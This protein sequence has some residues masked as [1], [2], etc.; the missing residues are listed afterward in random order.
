MNI[1][2]K[3]SWHVRNKDNVERVRRDEENARKDEKER[4]K[5]AALAEQ[6]ART[7]LLR[8]RAAKKLIEDDKTQETALVLADDK[9]KHINFFAEIEEGLR[10]GSNPEYEA[11]KRAEQE[12]RERAIGLL[13]Y[14]GQSARDTQSGVKP[15][16]VKSHEQRKD[17]TAASESSREKG[18]KSSLDPLN[19][20]KKYLETKKSLKDKDRTHKERKHKEKEKDSKIKPKKTIEEMRKE[21]IRRE[22][23]EHERERKLLALVRGDKKVAAETANYD[24]PYRYN[25]QY[26][27][28]FARK[29]KNDS[30]HRPY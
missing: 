17:P 20:M 22:R 8:G 30:R 24:T 26:N 18:K 23:E 13:T 5:R 9:A 6:E 15:W 12:K 27:P 2:P 16:Y 29:P 4:E 25:S 3:K 1:L 10:H 28:E 11:E 7:A 14:L 21:R 19:D